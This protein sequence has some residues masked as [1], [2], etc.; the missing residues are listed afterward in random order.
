MKTIA[1]LSK[2]AFNNFNLS[3]W[4]T[5]IIFILIL[6]IWPLLLTSS[7]LSDWEL[8]ISG[9]TLYGVIGVIY[10]YYIDDSDSN[11]PNIKGSP[12]EIT[13]FA[14]YFIFFQCLAITFLF[15]LTKFIYQVTIS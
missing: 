2:H 12:I 15:R 7:N 13:M 10:Y 14:L 1:L 8:L 11:L 4:K 6:G 3:K 5:R 9:S